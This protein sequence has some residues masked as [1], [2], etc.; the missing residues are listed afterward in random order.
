MRSECAGVMEEADL[1]EC[2]DLQDLSLWSL[3]N[4]RERAGFHMP[5]H[6]RG[7]RFSRDFAEQ[8]LRLDLTEL[9]NTEDLHDPGDRLSLL[10]DQISLIYGS[11]KTYL[12][13]SGS[14]TGIKAMLSAVSSS[15]SFFLIAPNSHIS[16][17]SYFISTGLDYAYMQMTSL[18]DHQLPPGKD[19]NDSL[20]YSYPYTLPGPEDLERNLKLYPQTTAL[21]LTVPD[22]FGRSEDLRTIS[23]I[24]HSHGCLLLVDEAHGAHF[25]YDQDHFPADAMHSGADISVQSLHKTLPALTMTSLLHVSKE[26][27]YSGRVKE[28]KV[29]DAI[30]MQETSSP[31]LMLAASAE[32]A[33]MWTKKHGPRIFPQL[34]EMI[35][36]F[37]TQL[38]QRI[39]FDLIESV[40][41]LKKD[42][43][44][45]VIHIGAAGIHAI[46]IQREME[47][48]GIFVEYAD[49]YRMV[50]IV[51][52]WQTTED[53]RFLLDELSDIIYFTC[54]K[55][56]NHKQQKTIE[57]IWKK[58]YMRKPLMMM[59]SQRASLGDTDFIALDDAV[60]HTAARMIIPYPPGIPILVPGERITKEHIQFVNLAEGHTLKGMNS[61]DRTICCISDLCKDF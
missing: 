57:E 3:S 48:K 31:S 32:F 59:K 5:G 27:I 17:L 11:G 6:N 39:G 25:A 21:L 40:H 12:L 54:Q 16:V 33:I 14:S 44:R 24:A 60:G 42:S 15:N 50:C 18:E 52:P 35:Q 37:Q 2:A 22:Y 13:T 51:S 43:L 1:S 41:P 9:S 29:K 38:H 26:A 61:Q 56:S 53:F 23:E 45:I 47:K 8:L 20:G 34:R 4:T 30:L 7:A 19:T 10:L 46:D 36:K 55:D 49:P 28:Y 58:I